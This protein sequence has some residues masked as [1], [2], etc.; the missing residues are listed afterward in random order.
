MLKWAAE[1][2]HTSSDTPLEEIT[3]EF[4]CH[5]ALHVLSAWLTNE[6]NAPLC[7]ELESRLLH[8]PLPTISI[9]S[10]VATNKHR[11]PFWTAEL[12]WYFPTLHR[13]GRVTVQS[14]DIQGA[15]AVAL[16]ENRR[17]KDLQQEISVAMMP[18]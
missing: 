7:K 8:F 12:G 16:T 17:L 5:R 9:S 10:P 14:P 6:A 3:I 2:L 13:R 18:T 11:K 4:S 1:L 15:F